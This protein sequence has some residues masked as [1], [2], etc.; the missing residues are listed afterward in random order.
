LPA[1]SQ[2]I[3][4][5]RCTR[6]LGGAAR[7]SQA[8]KDVGRT[9]QEAEGPLLASG[10]EADSN[11]AGRCGHT[12]GA[13]GGGGADGTPGRFKTGL[14]RLGVAGAVV[15]D[16]VWGG[17]GGFAPA[18]RMGRQSERGDVGT[19]DGN[20]GDRLIGFREGERPRACELRT[21]AQALR[22][23][24]MGAKKHAPAGTAPL[25]CDLLPR[26]SSFQDVA[27]AMGFPPRV[28][29]GPGTH[30]IPGG[31]LRVSARLCPKRGSGSM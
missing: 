28:P 10:G 31:L 27:S 3:A 15:G 6:T 16:V 17:P 25:R 21:S 23:G 20:I 9:A 19:T 2:P 26:G 11:W 22:L 5:D 7:P 24:P 12:A 29:W 8:G 14:G 1:R 30:V 4:V 18:G 13:G